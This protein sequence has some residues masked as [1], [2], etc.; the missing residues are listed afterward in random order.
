MNLAPT[1][2]LCF[3]ST[4]LDDVALSCGHFV[5]ANPGANVITVFTDAPADHRSGSNEQK[6]RQSYA[7]DALRVRREEDAAALAVLHARPTWLGL[8]ECEYMESGQPLE[9][10]INKLQEA[11]T[12]LDA[13]SVFVPL[14]LQH[15]DHIAVSTACLQLATDRTF[16]WYLYLDLPYA[17]SLPDLW[18]LRLADLSES[19]ELVELDPFRP[20]SDVKREA[21]TRYAS[22]IRS[23]WDHSLTA[24]ERYWRIEQIRSPE[25]DP[26]G[27]DGTPASRMNS[28]S[29]STEMTSAKP[30]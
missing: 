8:W 9:P 10:I 22:Q 18:E 15:S 19:A 20:T 7:P 5:A 17:L 30:A 26:Q 4:H 23:G 24:P 25:R 29:A 6:T 12:G 13:A 1:E 2:P 14:G 16:D 3:V 21:V 27:I 28:P 11:F